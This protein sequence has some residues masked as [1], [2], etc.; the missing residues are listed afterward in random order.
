MAVDDK[1][2]QKSD[3]PA[4]RLRHQ[5]IH[6]KEMDDRI[7]QRTAEERSALPNWRKEGKDAHAAKPTERMPTPSISVCAASISISS[8]RLD[9]ADIIS[10][11]ENSP[12]YQRDKST[13]AAI[14][15]KAEGKRSLRR[16]A[17]SGKRR[18]RHNHFLNPICRSDFSRK[19]YIKQ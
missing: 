18:Q 8:A 10:M 7:T 4:C 1:L 14:K 9:N 12:T 15:V 6:M 13:L 3:Y 2:E 19:Q 5:D 16:S 17:G 11:V